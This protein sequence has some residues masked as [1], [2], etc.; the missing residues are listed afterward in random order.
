VLLEI[1][2]GELLDRIAALE[3]R[4]ERADAEELSRVRQELAGL[5]AVRERSVPP[6][7]ELPGLLGQLRAVHEIL[8]RAEEGL[9]RC[10]Q[11]QDF[12]PRFA[13]LARA[14]R[15]N[16]AHRADLRRQ[17]DALFIG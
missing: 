9:R 13:D 14:V 17:I 4:A 8:D 10:E 6:A 2:P 3:V 7:S 15:V 1:S 11:A 12:G 5:T 16:E